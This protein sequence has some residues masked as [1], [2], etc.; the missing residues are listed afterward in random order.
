VLGQRSFRRCMRRWRK[1]KAK[2]AARAARVRPLAGSCSGR[3][4][5]S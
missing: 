4:I 5:P 3:G 2:A 1:L